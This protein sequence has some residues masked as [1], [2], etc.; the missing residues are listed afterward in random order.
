MER[1]DAV[2]SSQRI[3]VIG[4]GPA[5]LLAAISAAERCARVTLVERGPK[6]GRKLR[7]TGK[8]RCNITNAAGIERF[9]KAFGPN[10]RFLYGAFSR[11][12]RDDIIALLSRMGVPT[13][14]ER[15]GRI[16]PVS[17]SALDVANALER[18]VAELGVDVR[19][20]SRAKAVLLSEA[21]CVHGVALYHGTMDATAVIVATGGLSYPG[22]GSTGDGYSIAR[23]VGHA[24]VPTRAALA[25][26]LIGDRWVG[27]LSGLT[28]KNVA[29]RLMVGDPP[30]MAAR[31]FGE[32]LFTRSGLSGPIILTVS[33]HVPADPDRMPVFI[34]L[35]LKPAITHEEL[36]QR[37]IR[38]FAK[39]GK[40]GPYLRKLMPHALADALV[41]VLGL[42]MG[43]SLSQV[44]S[45]ERRSIVEALKGLRFTF[46]GLAPVEEAIVTAGGVALAEVDPRT[47]MSRKV[48]G[49]FFAGEVLD[50]DAE[51]GGYNLQAAFSTGWVAGMAAADWRARTCEAATEDSNAEA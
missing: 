33:R 19:P 32:M 13:K 50:L 20:N 43:R 48:G 7:L 4:G 10:G 9:I 31:E 6:T 44:T 42:D 5:G 45:S 23:Q 49:L 17:D 3:V 22:T 35:D 34:E 28:L 41:G 36:H 51:T 38:D 8:G 12:F 15:G 25:P 24:I 37:L 39:P 27:S 14:A 2:R 47:M 11:F 1:P 29:V 26:I 30:V 18:R 21:G 16:F 46:R 40:L